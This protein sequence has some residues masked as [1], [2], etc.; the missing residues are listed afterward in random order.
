MGIFKKTFNKSYKE[1]VTAE[2]KEDYKPMGNEIASMGAGNQDDKPI[3]VTEE[4]LEAED[5]RA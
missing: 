3:E 2:L 4:M 1:I 5:G